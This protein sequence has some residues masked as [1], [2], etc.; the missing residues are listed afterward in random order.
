MTEERLSTQR[1]LH[2]RDG[3][4][5]ES[6]FHGNDVYNTVPNGVIVAIGHRRRFYPWHQVIS[7]EAH[8]RDTIWYEIDPYKRPL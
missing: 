7:L 1:V 2:V 8:T 4:G 3:E 5:E 6:V